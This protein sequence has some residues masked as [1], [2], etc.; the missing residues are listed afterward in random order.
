MSNIN[1]ERQQH[2]AGLPPPILRTM[3]I[4]MHHN[5]KRQQQKREAK[6][7]RTC[8]SAETQQPS[9]ASSSR[10]RL[11]AAREKMAEGG[12][13]SIISIHSR[14]KR[15]TD[16]HGWKCKDHFVKVNLSISRYGE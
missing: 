13:S 9:T 7:P 2:N 15:A 14:K 12:I 4:M 1:N 11:H 6:K 3:P 5:Y 10:M 16:L 8:L